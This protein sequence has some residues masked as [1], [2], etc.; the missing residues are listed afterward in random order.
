LAHDLSRVCLPNLGEKMVLELE[1]ARE[2]AR[3]KRP[4]IR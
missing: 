4:A 2:Q 1:R 3:P